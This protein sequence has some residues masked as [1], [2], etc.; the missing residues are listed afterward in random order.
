M[1]IFRLIFEYIIMF[2]ND[3]FIIRTKTEM[4]LIKPSTRMTELILHPMSLHKPKR[5]ICYG[6]A[7]KRG[8]R[9][10]IN[11]LALDL[12]LGWGDT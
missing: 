8:R 3:L 7:W 5:G 10:R 12:L 1:N 9:R 11:K 4:N 2:T 6:K